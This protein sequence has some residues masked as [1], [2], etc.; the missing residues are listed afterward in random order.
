MNQLLIVA[1]TIAEIEPFFKHLQID[2]I[3]IGEVHQISFQNNRIHILITGVG[4]VNTAFAL[5]KISSMQFNF[6]I[7]AG[8]AGAFNKEINLGEVVLVKEDELSEMGAEDGEDFIKYEEMKLVGSST[9]YSSTAIDMNLL[10]GMKRVKSITVNK[11][12][13]EDLSIAKT[14]RLFNPDIESMEGAAFFACTKFNC[15]KVVQLRAISNY[16]ER[17]DKSKWQIKLAIN[18]LNTQLINLIHTL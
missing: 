9:F 5:G 4:M 18:N 8:I 10:N 3:N 15:E 7:N 12:H 13:G 17:R 2:E 14:I 1:A 16:V 11:V 6:A